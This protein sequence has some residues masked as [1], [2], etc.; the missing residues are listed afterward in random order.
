VDF[1]AGGLALPLP[2]AKCADGKF[3]AGA[4]RCNIA[5]RSTSNLGGDTPKSICRQS[6]ALSGSAKAKAEQVSE[7]SEARVFGRRSFIA[8]RSAGR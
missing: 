5:V 3:R 4:M 8:Q 1:G 2:D 6:T 7:I